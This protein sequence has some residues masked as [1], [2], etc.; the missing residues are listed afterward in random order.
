MAD[1]QI[2]RTGVDPSTKSDGKTGYNVDPGPYEAVVVQHITGTRMGQLLVYIP[3]WGGIQSNSENQIV[4]SYASPYY[5]KTCYTDNAEL[6]PGGFTSGQSYG[7]WMVPPDVGNRVL[8]TFVA[9][10]RSR[11]YWFACLYDSS[12]H[13]MVPGM[14]RNIGGQSNTR[15]DDTVSG[16]LASSAS[17][18]SYLPVTEYSTKEATAFGPDG[19]TNTPR[20]AHPVQ[21]MILVGQGLD[22]D[23]VRG[24][25][26]SSSMREAPSNVF[27]ISTPGRLAAPSPQVG[28]DS[29]IDSAQQVVARLGGH[30][31]VMDDGDKDGNDQLIRLRTAGGHQIL[32]NDTAD[33][34][35]KKKGVLYIASSSGNQWM[36]FSS[37]GSINV[38]GAAGFNVRSVGALNFHSDSQVNIH[39]GGTVAIHGE[40]GVKIDSLVSCSMEA[41]V[42][43]KVST[44]GILTL[45]ALGAATLSTGASLN[46]SAVGVLKVSGATVLLN[47]PYLPIPPVPVLPNMGNSL[48]DVVFGGT[49]WQYAPGAIKSICT[50]APAHEPWLDPGTKRRPAPAKAGSALGGLATSAALVAGS[51][52]AGSFL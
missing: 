34:D 15:I 48:P 39:S 44:D 38:Y 37:D 33:A 32:M 46:L 8:V 26:S 35:G 18:G 23:P 2:R 28:N 17:S 22:A 3:E 36:E 40:M 13:H 11:G 12:S 5:G 43:C 50:V 31:F 1:N 6:T 30:T 45:G 9:G 10:D 27:G 20:Y 16:P 52:V 14:A 7:M 41:L 47:S 42:S 51:R 24:A 49:S 4:V 29:R 25:I 19:L 21:S